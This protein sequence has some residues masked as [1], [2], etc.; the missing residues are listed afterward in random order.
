MVTVGPRT[1]QVEW[2]LPARLRQ[3]IRTQ[4]AKERARQ[5]Q[6]QAIIH[7]DRRPLHTQPL[8][9]AEPETKDS[10]GGFSLPQRR[11]FNRG[12]EHH[13]GDTYMRSRPQLQV[14]A[15]PYVGKAATQAGP[16]W[17][18]SRAAGI[19]ARQA[20][21]SK[22]KRRDQ[23][24]SGTAGQSAGRSWLR[25]RD[26]PYQWQA[27]QATGQEDV[28]DVIEEREQGAEQEPRKLLAIPLSLSLWPKFLF[29]RKNRES[30]QQLDSPLRSTSHHVLGDRPSPK[31]K[32]HDGRII[33]LR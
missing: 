3:P 26:V 6:R 4:L 16:T 2:R 10:V 22:P 18:P 11:V 9:R 30:D 7:F 1:V 24:R 8:L 28:A 17:L 12:A 33:D 20:R 14:A 15:P 29:G 13:T 19:A 32:V 27:E 23:V 31:K 21:A 25:E 5:R